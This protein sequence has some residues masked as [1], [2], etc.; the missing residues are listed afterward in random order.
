VQATLRASGGH[1]IAAACGQLRQRYR[2]DGSR[3]RSP[4]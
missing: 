3:D 2:A 4:S 1:D